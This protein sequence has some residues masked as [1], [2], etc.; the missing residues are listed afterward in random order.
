MG[1]DSLN[2]R[3]VPEPPLEAGVEGADTDVH[4]VRR[5]LHERREQRRRDRA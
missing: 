4:A 3:V 2:D 5:Q 1:P